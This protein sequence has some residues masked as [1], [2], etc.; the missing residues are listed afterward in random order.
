MNALSKDRGTQKRKYEF[1]PGLVGGLSILYGASSSITIGVTKVAV[2]D[3]GLIALAVFVVAHE[4]IRD[5]S[6]REDIVSNSLRVFVE[7]NSTGLAES[8]GSIYE[9]R[10][11]NFI[12]GSTAS[13]S[14]GSFCFSSS[15]LCASLN[16]LR[17]W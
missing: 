5:G 8:P 10:L 1:H 13:N 7:S 17:R 2:S 15:F 3:S 14:F 16:L 11:S 12:D 4:F 9:L 6:I